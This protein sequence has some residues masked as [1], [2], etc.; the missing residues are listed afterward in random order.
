MVAT[1]IPAENR[2]LLHN[3]SWQTFKTM[4][5]EMGCERNSRLAYH[6]GIIEIITPLMPHENSNRLIEVF[7]GVLCE[8]SGLEIRRG[9]SLTL[10]RDDLQKGAEPDSCYYIQN[11]IL[12]RSKENINLAINPPPDLVLEVEYSRSAIDKL[13]L[14]AAMGVPEFWRFNGSVLR[15]YTLTDRQYSEVSVSPTFAP[16]LV[17]EIPRFIQEARKNGEVATTRVFRAWVRQK[18]SGNE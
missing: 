1:T 13:R 6:N 17:R 14:Y 2:V 9:G 3:I 15:V 7:V 18:I 4:L 5:A 10:T 16:V 12:V 8:E 11:E